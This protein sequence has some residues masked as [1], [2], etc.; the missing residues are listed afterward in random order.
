MSCKI[1][2][3]ELR[4]IKMTDCVRKLNAFAAKEPQ[5]ELD[6]KKLEKL[7]QESKNSWKIESNAN[8]S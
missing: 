8:Y 4:V 1:L 6:G 5:V 3:A 2:N 7:Q